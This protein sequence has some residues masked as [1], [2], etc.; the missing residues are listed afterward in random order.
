M[1]RFRED[2]ILAKP[3]AGVR[4]RQLNEVA[5]AH[6]AL[7]AEVRRE[8]PRFGGWQVLR[9]PKGLAAEAAME[10]LRATGLFEYV[11]PD[12]RVRALVMPNDPQFTDGSLWALH[13]TGQNG[14]VADA[15]IDAPEAW[16]IRTDAENVVVGVI[17][18]GIDYTH[19]DLAGNMWS[20]PGE[21]PGNGM[22]DDG[23]GYV[24][25][26]HGINSIADSGDPLDDHYHGTHVA[27][28]IG[29]TGN[30]GIGVV[31]VA[32]QV[33][34]MA[35]KFL[36]ADGY[37]NTS[38][39][40]EC[41]NY[42]IAK[43]A[44]VLNNSWGSGEFSQ[45][46]S[47]AIAAAR[48]AGIIFVAAAGNE[49]T[50]TD[51]APN[52]PSCYPHDNIVAVM[53]TDRRDIGASFS[54]FGYTNVD[55][56]APGVTIWST[57]PTYTTSRMTSNSYPTSYHQLSGT[58]MATPHVVGAF[59]LLKAQY[60]SETYT[61][62]IHRMLGNTD[63]LTDMVD[64][65]YTEGR[66]NLAAALTNPPGPIVR[67]RTH[68][69]R[70]AV[71]NT[72]NFTAGDP[73]LT[74]LCSNATIGATSYAW[75][76]GDGSPLETV[77]HPT[78]VY[79]N[80]GTYQVTLTATA[81]NGQSRTKT[82]EVLVDQN[83]TMD[84][85]APFAWVDPSSHP[86]V[87][88]SDE[89]WVAYPLPFPFVFYGRTYTNIYIGSNGQLAFDTNGLPAWNGYPP[90]PAAPN[91]IICVMCQDLDPGAGG[92]IRVGTVGIA[93]QRQFVVT[94]NNIKQK[95]FTA[96]FTFQALLSEVHGDIKFQYLDTAVAGSMEVA[97]G[98]ASVVA[99]EHPSGWIA[100]RYRSAAS[101]DP[102]LNNGQAILF[103]RH[104]VAI[105]TNTATLLAGNANSALDPGEMWG[106]QIVLKNHLNLPLSGVTATLST[107]TIGVNIFT[108]TA[109]YPDLAPYGTATNATFYAYKIGR[110]V[111]A[112]TLIEFEHITTVAS[113]GRS[114]TN[115]FWRRVGRS[116]GT[117]TNNFDAAN[118]PLATVPNG[119]L[120]AT[121]FVPLSGYL[122]NDVNCSLRL[123]HQNLG[124][125][126]VHLYNPAGQSL[127]LAGSFLASLNDMGTGVCGSNEGRA[128]FDDAATNYCNN[129]PYVG[130]FKPDQC[131]LA[132]FN[133]QNAGGN[134]VLR[135]RTLTAETGTLNCWGLQII[136]T[137]TNWVAESYGSCASNSAPVADAQNL[138]VP[139]GVGTPLTLTGTDADYDPLTFLTNSLPAH[140]TLSAFNPNTGAITYTPNAG[141]LGPDSF[142][143]RVADGCVTSA[144]VTVNLTVG[145]PFTLW[146]QAY[147]G[148]TT[149]SAAPDADP[150][151]DGMSNT[152][153]FLAGFNPTNAAA[154][155]RILGVARADDEIIISY[156]AA[157]GDG[158]HS[159]GPKTNMLEIATGG[160]PTNFTPSG[161]MHVLSGGTGL[162]VVTNFTDSGGATN[163]LG[164]FYRIRVMTP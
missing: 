76:F 74:V 5:A 80:A 46:L 141:Y 13:N 129:A 99:L 81:P 98:A 78:H 92:S 125:V 71:F 60:P 105:A 151:G 109:S 47:D 89:S 55:L 90:D 84:P 19:P 114:Y 31:G 96:R 117:V 153:E 95:S 137:T 87:S 119:Y 33:K 145:T 48:D 27:G 106:E 154:A 152:N 70:T 52:Y 69:N 83:Y 126:Y 115:N 149:G 93:P 72:L 35:L 24:D 118:T 54:S 20:N 132:N 49:S 102:L 39:A 104:E 163:M 144:P 63:F 67:F 59:A 1:P 3:K 155:L 30:N 128:T 50:D 161:L 8:Y 37:G 111:P 9:L 148:G 91:N 122:L 22:D 140:G 18:S 43:G 41:V 21:I 75:D 12:Y 29:A 127:Q 131:C 143:F 34:L 139:P 112:G 130:T 77:T 73:P 94:W 58:S 110:N 97:R 61:Q 100:R 86:T 157:D 134:W 25:D 53:A 138:L 79:S 56:A 32:W 68:P 4:A 150:D 124:A 85:D 146:Q 44:H 107:T 66:L 142:T 136:A 11:E 26:V 36:G 156:R 6:R 120:Y 42:A 65:C 64:A 40:I 38:D 123:T 14:G 133:N 116:G 10:R 82:R 23:N 164:R 2:Q 88:L 103:T 162:G 158:T 108:N 28:T 121:N 51:A 45:A 159:P 15:D 57:M 113:T 16:N 17:D 7:G 62:L 160:S 101:S 147:F 135:I